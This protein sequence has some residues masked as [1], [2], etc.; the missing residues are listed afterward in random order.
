MV[1][2]LGN[3]LHQRWWIVL[4]SLHCSYYCFIRNQTDHIYGEYDGEVAS[5]MIKKKKWTAHDLYNGNVN[6]DHGNC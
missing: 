1:G 4:G 5:G 2:A 6:D 3:K